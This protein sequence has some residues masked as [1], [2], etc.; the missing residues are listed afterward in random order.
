MPNKGG[1]SQTGN[2][3]TDVRGAMPLED[4][5]CSGNA[6]A[7]RLSSSRRIGITTITVAISYL[8]EGT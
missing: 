6:R 5:G 7:I 3:R 8:A 4:E 2:N 1:E